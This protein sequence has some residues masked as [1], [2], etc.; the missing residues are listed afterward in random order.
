M[1]CECVSHHVQEGLSTIEQKKVQVN[2][3]IRDKCE[4]RD[5]DDEREWW[6]LGDASY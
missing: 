4:S 2:P 6:G 5:G 1:R 3:Y